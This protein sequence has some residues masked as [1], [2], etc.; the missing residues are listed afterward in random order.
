[1]KKEQELWHTL[2][3]IP[4]NTSQILDNNADGGS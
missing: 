1:M 3:T 2:S 4:K